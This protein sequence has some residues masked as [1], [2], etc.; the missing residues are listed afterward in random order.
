MSVIRDILNS[1]KLL[2]NNSL[3]TTGSNTFVGT[4]TFSGSL[5]PATTNVYDLGSTTKQFKDLYLSSASLY[6]DGQKVL[7]SNADTLTITTDVGQSIKLLETGADDI[8]LQT[9]TGNV[10]LKGTVELLSGKKIID[11]A[12]TVIQF[13]DSL[14]VTGSIQVSGTV[15]GVD[16]AALKSDFDTL[17]GKTLVSGSSQIDYS[18]LQNIPGGIVSSSTQIDS[19]GFLKVE[20]DNIVS[21][22]SQIDLTQTT[23]YSSGIKTRLDAENVVSSSAQ[24]TNL[25]VGESLIISNLTVNGTQT[26]VNST[27]LDIGDSIISLNG[28]GSVLGGIH[29][30][31]G[32]VSGSI[33]WHGT[34]NQWIAGPSGSE[35]KILLAT[36][37][38]VVSGSSQISFNGIT[39]KPTLVSGSSQISYSGLSSIPSGIVSGSSQI[40]YN[41][42]QN[43]PT[44]PTNNNQ[45]TNGAGY[46]TGYTETDTLNS[47]TGR[48][49]TTTNNISVGTLTAQGAD[50]GMVLRNWQA[51]SQYGMLGTANMAGEEYVII[52]DGSDT[53]LG[54][55]T[56]GSTYI[57]Y[58]AN[59]STNQLKISSAGAVF[60]GDVLPDV[61]GTQDLGSSTKRWNT[62]YTSD[63]SLSNGI[64]DYTIVEGEED[65]FLYNNKS[66]K[67]FK[68]ALIEVDPSQV[69]AKR[70]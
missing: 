42:I 57:R 24:I 21:G 19:F 28:T 63:L 1:T 50:G 69:P 11:S 5:I 2:L 59:T 33:L 4:Q 46:I 12:G 32:P 51:N 39:D 53:F 43:K 23:N 62:L 30:N 16:I 6:I 58:A 60:Y 31:D 55:G 64:G 37:D 3:P 34:D 61:N 8:I 56:G 54:S 38:N 14:G 40:D 48:G 17:E 36:G 49:A 29:V 66:G 27:Q 44:I 15:D 10:E 9:D 18:A 67:T 70:D 25:L 20:G 65:L 45:L 41:S 47:V 7:S 52:S 22:S 26:T 35:V 13:G 68:F